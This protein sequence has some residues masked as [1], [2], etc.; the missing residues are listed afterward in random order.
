MFDWVTN[1]ILS[2]YFLTLSVSFEEKK[3]KKNVIYKI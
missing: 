2:V 3:K 1:K